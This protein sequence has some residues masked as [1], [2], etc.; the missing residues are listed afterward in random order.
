MPRASHCVLCGGNT[1]SSRTTWCGSAKESPS[2]LLRQHL[3]LRHDPVDSQPRRGDQ[4]RTQEPGL[5]PLVVIGRFIVDFLAIHPFQ[6]GSG[7]LARALTTLRLLRVGTATS[8]TRRSGGSSRT[9]GG[10]TTSRCAGHSSPCATIRRASQPRHH[11]GPGPEA[12]RVLHDEH[13]GPGRGAPAIGPRW[14][15]RD[16]P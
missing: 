2:K 9:T 6:D 13:E 10:S 3:P 8:R 11:R 4:C 1:R 14:H 15:Q 5:H 7:R 16:H 12:G